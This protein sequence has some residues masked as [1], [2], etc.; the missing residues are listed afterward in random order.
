M[1]NNNAYII[2]NHENGVKKFEKKRNI[3]CI[4]CP[5]GCN[6][7]VWYN[8]NNE[9]KEIKGYSCKRGLEYGW[10]ESTNPVRML[11]TTIQI[12][13]GKLPVVPVKSN[14]PLPKDLLF[15]CMNVIRKVQLKAPVRAG[16]VVIKNILNTGVDI[17]TTR[18]M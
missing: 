15:E 8:E 4:I 10:N 13:G 17:V 1:L 12:D 2:N 16:E 5:Q 9:V 18:D 14:K 3:T 11:T 7:E 6:L